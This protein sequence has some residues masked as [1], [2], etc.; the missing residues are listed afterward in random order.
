MKPSCICIICQRAEHK[1]LAFRKSICV[2]TETTVLKLVIWCALSGNWIIGPICFDETI[3]KSLWVFSPCL[4]DSWLIYIFFQQTELHAIRMLGHST[5][6][7][8]YSL[9]KGLSV[10]VCGLPALH[11]PCDSYIR[12][13]LKG[14]VNRNNPRNSEKV[15]DSES[16]EINSSAAELDSIR[17]ICYRAL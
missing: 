6:C 4:W 5:E 15:K 8:M 10:Q 12:V 11:T 1:T 3:N 16:Q 13:P 14:K 7:A 9:R 2:P 17:C